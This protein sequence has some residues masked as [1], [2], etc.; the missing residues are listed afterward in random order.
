MMTRQMTAMQEPA[1]IPLEVMCQERSRKQASIVYQFQSMDI[2]QAFPSLPPTL[3]PLMPEEAA[4]AAEVDGVCEA[5]MVMVMLELG[6]TLMPD[7]AV[8]GML[9]NPTDR[10]EGLN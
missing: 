8:V 2:L 5:G 1:N 10:R 6:V 3:M 4:A 7:M 9:D